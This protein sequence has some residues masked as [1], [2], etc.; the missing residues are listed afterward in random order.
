VL[1]RIYA[2]TFQAFQVDI[3]NIQRGRLQNDL[4]LVIVLKP[5]G[6]LAVTAVRGPPGRLYIGDIPGIRPKG[7][8]KSGGI[9]RSCPHLKVIWLSQETSILRPVI[10][11]I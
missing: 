10:M 7:P 6:V 5:V 3:L 11:Q 2:E 9:E 8:E 1:Q 4:V